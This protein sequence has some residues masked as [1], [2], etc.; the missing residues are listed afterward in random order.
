MCMVDLKRDIENKAIVEIQGICHPTSRFVLWTRL[1]YIPPLPVEPTVFLCVAM[2]FLILNTDNN[3]SDDS[4]YSKSSNT[5][6]SQ[7][8]QLRK[9]LK[10]WEKSFVEDNDRK[11]S[12]EDIKQNVTIGMDRF[13]THICIL[14]IQPQNTG[15]ISFFKTAKR[16]NLLLNQSLKTH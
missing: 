12:R 5:I 3:I 13:L 7:L 1:Q 16:E 11:A 9:E 8:T 2:A 4:Q 6:A 14:I 10:A 15:C